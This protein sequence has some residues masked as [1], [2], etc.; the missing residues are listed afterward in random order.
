M[1]GINVGVG[2]APAFGDG[3]KSAGVASSSSIPSVAKVS[4]AASFVRKLNEERT[5]AVEHLASRAT[6]IATR[7][8]GSYPCAGPQPDR[9]TN[10]EMPEPRSA[11]DSLLRQVSGIKDPFTRMDPALGELSA[12]LD[13][14]ERAI[15]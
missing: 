10:D 12:A 7:L 6:Q 3:E 14:I 5:D 2:R 4:E 11:L 15:G 1:E 13:M 8:A 9:R